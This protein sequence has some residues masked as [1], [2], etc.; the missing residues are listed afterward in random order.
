MSARVRSRCTDED[1]LRCRFAVSPLWETLQGIRLL[2]DPS[3][4]ALH[5]TWVRG[6][7]ARLTGTDLALLA[8]LVPRQGYT[9]DFVCPPP[10]GMETTIVEQLAQVR[11]A[12]AALVATELRRA[13]QHCDVSADAEVLQRL[14]RRPAHARDRI[15]ALLGQV[16][17]AA[18]EPFWERISDLLERDVAF[19]ARLVA[20]EGL[21]ALLDRLHPGV[22]RTG[23]TVRL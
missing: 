11:A 13:E 4:Q 9:P 14:R 1:L 22:S 21:T 5:V 16:W 10:S 3:R 6:A 15:A 2:R 12:P 7:R 19:H 17:A 8:P 20:E 18:V 23:A